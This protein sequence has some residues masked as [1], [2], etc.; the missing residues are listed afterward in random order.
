MY[1]LMNDAVLSLHGDDLSITAIS[2]R[3]G[4]VGFDYVQQ[5]ARELFS[6]HP[7]LQHSHTDRANK[8]AALVRAKDPS[9]NAALFVAPAPGCK[10]AQVG[11][12][13]ASIDIAAMASLQKAQMKGELDAVF[14]DREIWRRL[15]A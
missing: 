6:E 1:F 3:F 2:R 8:L 14:A 13:F 11:M 12:R 9:I 4:Q 10:P 5:L 7:M 15:A